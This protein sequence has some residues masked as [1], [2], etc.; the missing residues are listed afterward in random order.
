[1]N[2][3]KKIVLVYVSFVGLMA[4]MVALA[5]NQRLDLVSTDYYK[6]EL[7]YQEKIDRM[8]AT[9]KLS[10]KIQF[11]QN[12]D[13][14]EIIFPNEFTGKEIN[15]EILFYC[16][17]DAR[18]DQQFKLNSKTNQH[19]ISLKNMNKTVYTI[20]VEFSVDSVNYYTEETIRIK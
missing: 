8:V 4:T 5:L 2:W 12:S 13:Q 14:L 17:S 3:G 6:Q 11:K 9:N 10:N 1:M 16:P 20:Q 18:N 15:G 7:H 19:Q